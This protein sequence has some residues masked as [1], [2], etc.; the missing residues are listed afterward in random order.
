VTSLKRVAYDEDLYNSESVVSP[1]RATGVPVSSSY[2]AGAAAFATA[3][4]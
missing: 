1:Q 4:A 2:R 3:S